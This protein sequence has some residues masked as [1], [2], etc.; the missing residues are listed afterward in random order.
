[1]KLYQLVLLNTQARQF[2]VFN[3]V[4]GHRLLGSHI[5]SHNLSF[6]MENNQYI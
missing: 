5:L 2:M 1:M 4:A 3:L 6:Q